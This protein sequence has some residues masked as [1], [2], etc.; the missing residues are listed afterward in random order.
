MHI[1]ISYNNPVP[2][3]KQIVDQIR[4]KVLSGELAPGESLPSIRQLAEEAGTSVITTK[5]A[6]SELEAEGIIVTRAGLGSFVAHLDAARAK[7]V[8]MRSLRERLADIVADARGSG[9]TDEELLR[10][11]REAMECGGDGSRDGGDGGD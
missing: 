9:V 10:L 11:L 4:E 8:R 5:R 7:A 2:L 3:Y 1:S 6:Y